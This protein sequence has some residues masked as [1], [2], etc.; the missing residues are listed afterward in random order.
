M[1]K[2]FVG[3]GEKIDLRTIEIGCDRLVYICRKELNL[4]E[5]KNVLK[6]G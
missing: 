2:K 1:S 5:P 3:K 6:Y 4:L